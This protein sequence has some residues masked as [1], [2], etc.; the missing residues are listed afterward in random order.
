VVTASGVPSKTRQETTRADISDAVADRIRVQLSKQPESVSALTSL[1]LSD[2]KVLYAS[3]YVALWVEPTGRPRGVA[4]EAI[5][6]LQS[7]ADEGL[8]AAVYDGHFLESLAVTVAS[9][10]RADQ[11]AAFDLALSASVLRYLRHVHR[12][13]LD[14]Q[15][16][17]LRLRPAPE[18]HDLPA[19]LRRAIEHGRIAP[20]V[21]ELRPHSSQYSALR[22]RL[23]WYRSLASQG[24]LAS[25]EWPGRL[26]RAGD[27]DTRV[28]ALRSLLVAFGDLARDVPVPD[29]DTYD[30][31]IV[32][33]VKRFQIRHGLDPD[34][35]VGSATQE[36]LNV[37]FSD[38][39]RQI[40]LA[41]ERLRW[42]SDIPND[43]TVVVNIPT[44]SLWA[45]NGDVFNGTPLLDTR[46]IVGEAV[47]TQTPVFSDT[48][49]AVIFRPYWNIPLSILRREILPEIRR[50]PGY[51]RGQNLEIVRGAGDDAEYMPA[52]DS[53]IAL[54][55]RGELR[56]RQRPG[57]SN[58]LG[59]VKFVFPNEDAVYLHGS[60]ARRLFARPRR[61]FSHGC[62]RVEDPIALAE[63]VLQSEPGW[64]RERIVGAT[65]DTQTVSRVVALSRPIQVLLFYTTAVVM[66][67]SIHFASDIYGHDARLERALRQHF[68]Q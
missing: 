52:T 25:S 47:R 38:R 50:D 4:R 26:L 62:V 27:R 9:S 48:M 66:D 12:G 28:P 31:A 13:R 54:L 58:A 60:P 1:V 63:W 15:S 40:E 42:L 32:D 20:A 19:R 29:D 10:P 21:A 5:A 41:L 16:V 22:E 11:V 23:A 18:I 33:G 7:A 65:L 53:N 36:A 51:L 59:L 68:N 37:P 24:R 67:G 14:P 35:V 39:I 34:G 55:A 57:P 45:W 2:L 46:V 17:G 64:D 30:G 3:N 49:E 43:R 44:F 8:D 6:V 61:D 56:L